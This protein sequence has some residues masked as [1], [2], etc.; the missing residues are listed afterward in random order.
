M[1][2]TIQNLDTKNMSEIVRYCNCKIKKILFQPNSNVGELLS[3]AR[4]RSISK[5]LK[6]Q[7]L[8]E[9]DWGLVALNWLELTQFVKTIG[10]MT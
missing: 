9:D 5:K 7:F 2:L 10:K 3:T 1:A 4:R 8:I 6:P